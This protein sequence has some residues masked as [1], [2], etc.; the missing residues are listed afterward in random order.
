MDTK[1]MKEMFLKGLR[2]LSHKHTAETL[3]D[4]STYLGASDIGHCPRRVIMD[5]INNPDHDLRSHLWFKRGHMAEDIVAEIYDSIGFSNYERQVEI[6]I[7]TDS[8]P[9]LV[10]IDFVFTSEKHKI[11]SILEVKSGSIPT[12]PYGSWESQLHLQMGAL[13]RKYPN[14]EIRGAIIAVDISEGD[15]AF[16]NS[17][18]P[19]DPLYTGLIQHAESIWEGYQ[20]TLAGENIDLELE[21]GPL[22]G[23]CDSIRTCPLFAKIK[24]YPHPS[25]D[26]YIEE[27][28]SFVE[29]KEKWENIV[30]SHKN[31]LLG[32]VRNVGPFQAGGL[33]FREVTRTRKN[34][35]MTR[36]GKFLEENG[37]SISEFEEPSTFSFLEIKNAPKKK[38]EQQ[39]AA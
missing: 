8:T 30:K 12:V 37:A 25:M 11:K 18:K 28:K 9:I 33:L 3:G 22:C 24:D 14:Y 15:L 21:P 32:T 13:A 31:S 35:D 7:S 10:H 36:L 6:D 4:R 26:E 29:N 1:Q 27:Y 23:F 34:L 20:R 16:F 5:R 17:Y 19:S 38:Q 2:T 39:E